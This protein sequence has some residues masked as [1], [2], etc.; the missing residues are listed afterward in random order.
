MHQVLTELYSVPYTVLNASCPLPL[1]S[2]Q[3]SCCSSVAQCFYSLWPPGLQHVSFPVLHSLPE[4]AQTHVRWVDD[5][6]QPP[7]PLSPPSAPAFNLSQ[8]QGFFQWVSS[9]HQVAKVWS[10]SFSISPSREYSGLISRLEEETKNNNKSVPFNSHQFISHVQLFVTPRWQHARLLCPSPT[11]RACSYSRPSS[12]WCH[13]TIS[14]SVITNGWSQ[15]SVTVNGDG[16]PWSLGRD[17]HG[18][19]SRKSQNKWRALQ[20]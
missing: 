7:H 20:A 11:P 2:F 12:R 19:L 1:C 16:P 15:F 6:I 5:A 3:V 8:C 14:S 18:Q 13:P 17:F 10:Y 9:S 4:F